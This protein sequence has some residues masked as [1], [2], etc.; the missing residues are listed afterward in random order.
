[1]LP[2]TKSKPSLI[3]SM[4]PFY[5]ISQGVHY[6]YSKAYYDTLAVI[7]AMVG[8]I[9]RNRMSGIINQEQMFGGGA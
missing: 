7:I 2:I 3:E 5:S 4:P 6:T 8:I 9:R 1:V